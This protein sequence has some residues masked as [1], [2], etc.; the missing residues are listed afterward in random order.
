MAEHKRKNKT[1]VVAPDM[2]CGH[3]YGLTPPKYFSSDKELRAKQREQWGW[4]AN[5]VSN[6][7]KID[8]LIVNGDAIDGKGSKSGGTELI[9]TDRVEQ[10]KIAAECLGEFD[11]REI[12]IVRGTPYHTGKD[13]D[14]ED[15]LGQMVKA[16]GVYNRLWLDVNGVVFD[17][18]HHT[19]GSSV[20]ASRGRSIAKTHMWNELWAAHDMQPR[21]DII[22][23]SHVH[24]YSECGGSD[25]WGCTTPALQ[26]VGS[27]FGELRCEG[28]VDFGLLSF[29]V[30]RNGMWSRRLHIARL[31]KQKAKS[32]II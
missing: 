10:C 9:T 15:V 25:W 12:I 2:H 32:Y 26:G 18:R 29:K 13:E 19:S 6:I 14:F 31:E 8:C 5:E 20:P 22:V 17:I 16:S 21:A 28:I 30:K 23:R 4:F 7:G 3:K 27:K 24:Y 1:I 11:T